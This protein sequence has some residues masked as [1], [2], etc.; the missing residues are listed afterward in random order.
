ML[1][2]N[3]YKFITT[4]IN[5]KTSEHHQSVFTSMEKNEEIKRVGKKTKDEKGDL[6]PSKLVPLIVFHD[7]LEL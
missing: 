4:H 5:I 3:I 6:I 7:I 2:E 1:N